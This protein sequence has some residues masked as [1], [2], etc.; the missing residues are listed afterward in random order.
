MAASTRPSPFHSGGGND[1][2]F[3]VVSSSSSSPLSFPSSPS[4][5]VPSS[6]SDHSLLP[7][8]R[9]I[10]IGKSES[11]PRMQ[12]PSPPL[13]PAMTD[14]VEGKHDR[15]DASEA[16]VQSRLERIFGGGHV[17]CKLGIV[18]I[19]NDGVLIEIK[20]FERWSDG[21]GQ[22]IRYRSCFSVKRCIL[23]LFGSSKGVA[24]DDVVEV[25]KGVG[26]EVLRDDHDYES[27]RAKHR[28][29]R[30]GPFSKG[31]TMRIEEGDERTTLTLED[32]QAQQETT[33]S[34]LAA[35]TKSIR[36]LHEVG[37]PQVVT[38]L[39]RLY[40]DL[41]ESLHRLQDYMRALNDQRI[42]SQTFIVECVLTVEGK[43]TPSRQ[44][45]A[46]LKQWLE[47]RGIPKY[48]EYYDHVVDLLGRNGIEKKRKD[49][50]VQWIGITLVQGGGNTSATPS[51]S[52][53]ME[54]TEE[55]E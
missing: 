49:G 20:R 10:G 31:V 48:A 6:P 41:Q 12:I 23:Y 29:E 22:L 1:A 21:M 50:I 11:L 55:T 36:H 3:V 27:L 40:G 9:G 26:I 28:E 17:K 13:P 16:E 19:Y 5:S 33:L 52:S 47:S 35:C 4:L 18:D 43:W 25:C 46:R 51:P 38:D 32:Y 37:H 8:F 54:E 42:Q 14:S 15:A 7:S 24:W 44:L 2:S 53:M 30:K 39:R 34:T 45:E